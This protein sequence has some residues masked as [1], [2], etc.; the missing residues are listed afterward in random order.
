MIYLTPAAI[1]YLTQFIL[2]AAI[3]LYLALRLPR[4][5]QQTQTTLL[6]AFFAATTVFILLLFYDVALPPSQR[7]PAVYLQNTVTGVIL[8][9]LLQFAYHFPRL[10]P[11]KKRESRLALGFSILYT[12]WEVQFAIFRFIELNGG[13]VYYRSGDLDNALAAGFLWVPVVF[14]RQAIYADDRR[15]TWVRKLWQP[16]GEE[17]Q[18]ARA[19]AL[20]FVVTLLLGLVNVLRGLSF[21]STAIYQVMLSIGLLLVLFA[22]A[23]VYINSLPEMTSFMVKLAGIMLTTL[24]TILGAVGWVMTPVYA[25]QYHPPLSERQTLRFTPNV[26]GGYDVTRL[27]F[28]FDSD[29]GREVG[30]AASDRMDSVALDFTFRF[31]GRTSQTVYVTDMGMVS[32]GQALAQRDVQYRYGTTPAIFALGSFYA[33]EAGA[34]IFAKNQG[35]RLTITWLR[36]P[37]FTQRQAVFTFQLVLDRSGVFE[38]THERLPENLVYAPDADPGES[39]WIVG[40]VPGDTTRAP[41]QVTFADVPLRGDPGGFAQD[42]Y[43]DF[44]RYLHQLLS[45]LAWLVAVSLLAAAGFPLLL[46]ASLVQPL[47]ALLSGVQQVNAGKRAITIP[48]QFRDEIGFLTESFNGMI[49]QLHDLVT[50]LEV[51]VADRTRD[52]SALYDVAAIAGRAQNLETLLNESLMRTMT[53]LHSQA[54]AILLI[55]EKKDTA[56]PTRLRIV[57]HRGFPLDVPLDR[58]MTASANGL[59]AMM[60]EQRQPLLISDLSTDPRVPAAMRALGARGLLLAPLQAER[61][62]SGVVGLLR[63]AGQGFQVEEVALLATVSD[64]ISVAIESHRLR[65]AAQQSALLEERQRLARDLHDSVTQSLYGV[66]T[67]AE[68]GQAQLEAGHLTQTSPIFARIGETARQ[69]VREMRLFIHQLRPD[70]LQQEGLVRALRLRLAAVEGRADVRTRLLADETLQVPTPLTSALYRIAQEALN[71][72]LRHARARTVTVH[73]RRDGNQ[74]VLEVVDDG[75]GFDSETTHEGGMGL[76]SMRERAAEIGGEFQIRSAPGA[77]TTVRVAVASK[78]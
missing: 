1:G 72:A 54:G 22:F 30:M 12:L 70:V 13:H 38:I 78:G 63:D 14:I 15:V 18:A 37:G 17:A 24:L 44:R 75:C 29:L 46:Y 31:F 5:T 20:L 52:L 8:I 34:G 51:R 67:L 39:A 19:F 36:L 33:P 27:A 77:G 9:F 43:L 69:A 61:Q 45:P 47:N 74:V 28:Q 3:T 2:A 16:R 32:V 58:E 11:R 48:I 49:A 41:Q 57:A 56:E 7:L 59:L 55:G 71:N 68:G 62:V 65:Q 21:I 35:D 42:Y 6:A 53:A 23:A 76:G 10:D 64:Q 66:V 50:N 25:A 40:A 4:S 73:L 60:R 26:G